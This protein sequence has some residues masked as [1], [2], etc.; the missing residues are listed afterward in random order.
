M[1]QKLHQKQNEQQVQSMQKQINDTN[2]D[3]DQIEHR[4]N[5]P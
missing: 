4:L 2:R 5:E 1:E 3:L